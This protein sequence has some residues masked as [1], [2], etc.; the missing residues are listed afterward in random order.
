MYCVDWSSDGAY[1]YSPI[2]HKDNRRSV[3]MYWRASRSGL[4]RMQDK[5]K[6][7]LLTDR[8]EASS[9]LPVIYLEVKQLNLA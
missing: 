8:V 3:H 5:V 6:V 7:R 9:S 4:Y 1:N 2:S